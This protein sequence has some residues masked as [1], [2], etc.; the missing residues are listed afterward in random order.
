MN[1]SKRLQIAFELHRAGLVIM[2]QN[3]RRKF[4]DESDSEIEQRFLAWLHER[5]GAR[6]G[7][8]EG[9]VRAPLAF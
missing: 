4:P 2:R 7:D 3:L 1:A 9:K 8:G 6:F 5:P